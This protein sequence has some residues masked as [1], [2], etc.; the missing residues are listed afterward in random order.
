MLKTIVVKKVFI[1]HNYAKLLSR[2][3]EKIDKSES[4]TQSMKDC[5]RNSNEQYVYVNR[6]K[7]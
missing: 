1:G 2:T 6:E 5:T 3:L 7:L 4:T